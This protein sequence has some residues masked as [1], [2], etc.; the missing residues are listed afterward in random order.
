MLPLRQPVC[1]PFN[2]HSEVK[3]WTRYIVSP[4]ARPPNI[5]NSRLWSVSPPSVCLSVYG[6]GGAPNL[7]LS[8]ERRFM[9]L[10]LSWYLDMLAGFCATSWKAART[11]GS[12]NEETLLLDDLM[13]DG[14]KIQDGKIKKTRS[15][16]GSFQ[17]N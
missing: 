11:S 10:G 9:T 7:A 6:C 4:P 3:C 12:C 8:L 16:S 17:K 1:S 5:H 15:Y 14:F 2:L 13:T